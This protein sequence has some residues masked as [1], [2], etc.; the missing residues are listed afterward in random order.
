MAVT[1]FL[2]PD[3][4]TL[5]LMPYL[6]QIWRKM[7]LLCITVSENKCQ[8]REGYLVHLS[9]T[10]CWQRDKRLGADQGTLRLVSSYLRLSNLRKYPAYEKSKVL[11]QISAGVPEWGGI[12]DLM[13]FKVRLDLFMTVIVLC[14]CLGWLTR[15][16]ELITAPV[17]LSSNYTKRPE[18]HEAREL[19]CVLSIL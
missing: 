8:A 12:I 2:R 5:N 15:P 7:W 13:S 10:A 11:K 16:D 17:L 3:L 18:V 9:Y 6:A 14:D 4:E 19:Q 1:L